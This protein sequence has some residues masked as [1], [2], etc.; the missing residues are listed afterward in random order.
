MRAG[1]V[2]PQG[3]SGPDGADTEEQRQGMSMLPNSV[4]CFSDNGSI[5]IAS[6]KH[7]FAKGYR[8]PVSAYVLSHTA[9]ARR[10]G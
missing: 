2:P 7:E 10:S 8:F 9:V 1:R 4:E 3:R 6:D 5:S